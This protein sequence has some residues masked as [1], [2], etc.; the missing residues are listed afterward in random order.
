[1]PALGLQTPS[2]STP[3]RPVVRST[4]GE[5]APDVP[6]RAKISCLDDK[7]EVPGLPLPAR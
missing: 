2:P 4:G 1:V 6:E 7:L 3:Y 5:V